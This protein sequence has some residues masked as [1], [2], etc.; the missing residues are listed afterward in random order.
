MLA[1]AGVATAAPDPS[2]EKDDH[3]HPHE[4]G[5][6]AAG[7]NGGRV[8]T[9]VKPY[10]EFFVTKDRKVRITAVDDHNKAI[11][12]TGQSVKV[13]GGSRSNPTRMHFKKVDETL[14]SDIAFPK[15]NDF[16][17]VVRIKTSPDAKT[18]LEKFHINLD[19]C[20]EC[21][22]DEYACICDHGHEHADGEHEHADDG[23]K[24]EKA[25][26]KQE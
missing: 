9:S 15:G 12:L 21:K 17:V 25:G 24:H 22:L 14:V 1:A 26:K 3:D 6:K 11:A 20:P 19:K 18:V 2:G 23:H 13:I 8:I 4:H 7:P 16:P 10:L 5:K